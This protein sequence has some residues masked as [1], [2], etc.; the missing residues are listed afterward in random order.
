MDDGTPC[1]GGVD[2]GS[3]LSRVSAAEKLTAQ[4]TV[5]APMAK[6]KVAALREIGRT[7][8]ESAKC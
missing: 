5:V 2:E 3:S 4:A 8:G 6:E 7:Q 1:M